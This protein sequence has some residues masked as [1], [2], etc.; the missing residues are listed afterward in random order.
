MTWAF[1]WRFL[2]LFMVMGYSSVFVMIGVIASP[3]FTNPW[4]GLASGILPIA[5]S[6]ALAAEY[7][8]IR[9]NHVPRQD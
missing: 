9:Y 8:Q 7:L 5:L 1:T 4:W 3:I 2:L 6:F